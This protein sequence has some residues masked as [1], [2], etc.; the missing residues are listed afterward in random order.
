V[1]NEEVLQLVKEERD[2]LNKKEEG[3]WSGHIL[4]RNCLLKHVVEE[5]KLGRTEGTARRRRRRRKQLLQEPGNCQ[6]KHQSAVCGKLA[7][8]EFVDMS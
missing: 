1:K 8:D 5:K 3:N 4:H 7:L 2:I 6:A